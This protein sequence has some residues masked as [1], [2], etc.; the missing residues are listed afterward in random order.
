MAKRQ[1]V[2][3]LCPRPCCMPSPPMWYFTLIIWACVFQ[4]PNQ[5]YRHTDRH[6]DIITDRQP[7]KHILC[8][9]FPQ[10]TPRPGSPSSPRLR[11]GWRELPRFRV[12]VNWRVVWQLRCC[13]RSY[14]HWE[15]LRRTSN[16]WHRQTERKTDR[17][18][19]RQ[20]HIQPYR[21]IDT[22]TDRPGYHLINYL[23]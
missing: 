19:D 22:R 12:C 6:I 3:P 1:R 11:D 5:T 2:S 9:I 18:T 15:S 17:Q 13:L 7:D 10:L 21:E 8:A 23:P 20:T 14:H 4:G 16:V